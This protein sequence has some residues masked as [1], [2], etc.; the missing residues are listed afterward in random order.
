MFETSPYPCDLFTRQKLHEITG[1]SDDVLA[2]WLKEELL[3]S[4]Q[5]ESRRHRRFSYEQLHIAKVLDALR[6][7]GA[8]ISVLRAYSS[9]LQH[10]CRLSAVTTLTR[11]EAHSLPHLTLQINRFKRG[12][13][14]EILNPELA[15]YWDKNLNVPDDVQTRVLAESI[16]DIVEHSTIW[17]RDDDRHLVA[18]IAKTMSDFDVSSFDLFRELTDPGHINR[19]GQEWNWVTW[20]NAA[21]EVD[22]IS[23]EGGNMMTTKRPASAAFWLNVTD[24]VCEL[25]SQDN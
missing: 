5:T 22:Y 6:T 24:L 7:L 8:N 20:L 23:G 10:G 14:V 4:V 2:Y 19:G 21:G 12:E 13:E 16:D 25:W 3:V 18:S 15:T 17:D 9:F 11:Q 1:I